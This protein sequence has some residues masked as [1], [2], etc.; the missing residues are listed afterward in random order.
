[1]FKDIVII[2]FLFGVYALQHSLFSTLTLKNLVRSRFPNLF[3]FYRLAFNILQFS[4]FI[5]LW[6]YIP[7]PNDIIWQLDGWLLVLART[8]QLLA[9]AGLVAALFQFNKN[10]FLGLAQVR[11]YFKNH[12]AAE[13]D[14]NYQLSTHGPYAFSRHPIYLFTIL[15]VLFEPTMTLFKLLLLIWLAGY[16]YIGSFFEE[17]RLVR[18]FGPV[19]LSYQKEVSRIIPFKWLAGL[20]SK[21]RS[22]SPKTQQDTL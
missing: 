21:K 19:Y 9:I 4:L 10:E 7:K 3:S 8:S 18:E 20:A 14:E 16:F 11:R 6:I 2:S 1:M 5:L 15:V 22:F 12:Q 13:R 17:R